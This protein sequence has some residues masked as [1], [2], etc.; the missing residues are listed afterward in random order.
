MYTVTL[1]MR[2]KSAETLDD[3]KTVVEKFS[4]GE[5]INLDDAVKQALQLWE[6]HADEIVVVS[7]QF[8]RAS[9]KRW[10]HKRT[11]FHG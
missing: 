10:L 7:S 6:D 9:Q 3:W 4:V 2:L 11:L 8:I 1:R 5:C